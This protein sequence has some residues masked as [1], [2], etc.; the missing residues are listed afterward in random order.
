M[1]LSRCRLIMGHCVLP[2]ISKCG[3]KEDKY[4]T[5]PKTCD[6]DL[7]TNAGPSEVLECRTVP[8]PR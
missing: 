4:S 7:L 6:S 5:L 8:K 2:D 1:L 3:K